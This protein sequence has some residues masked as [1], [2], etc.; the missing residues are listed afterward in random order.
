MT[1]KKALEI[2]KSGKNVFLTGEP[3]SGKT[4]TVNQFTE[5]LREDFKSY[6]VTASTGIAATHVNGMTIHSWAGI[7]IKKGLGERDVERI[8]A[9]SYVVQRILSCQVLIIDE[10]SMI[11][12]QFLDDLDFVLRSVR[13]TIGKD[14]GPFGGIQMVFVGDFFQLPPVSRDGEAKFAFESEAWVKADPQICYLTEQHRQGDDEFLGILR[15]IRQGSMTEEHKARLL[16]K[17][18]AK[19]MSSKLFTHNVDVDHINHVEL[20]KIEGMPTEFRM[21]ERGIPFMVETLKSHCLSPERLLLKE[22]AI[23]MFTR[24]N[25]DEG[26]VNG[27]LGKVIELRDD[28]FP[29][30]EVMVGNRPE[31]IEV[32]PAKWEIEESGQIKASISQLPLRLAWAITVHKS[33]GMSLDSAKI[34]LQRSFEHGQGYVAIS[35]VRSLDGL[36]LEGA[37]DMA[38][39]MHPKVVEKDGEFREASNM[40]DT[41]SNE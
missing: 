37:N 15:A 20:N 1:Q 11:N 2:L 5:W 22:G 38:F 23:V 6:A 39:S 21:K 3:G 25:F 32:K 30:V 34:D 12:G 7:G 41:K 27:T 26:Y 4:H 31:C 35:R 8:M 28:S 36:F 24:N 33:Q 29:V 9:K 17:R 13:A 19:E 16:E 18:P 14:V 10:V 40:I